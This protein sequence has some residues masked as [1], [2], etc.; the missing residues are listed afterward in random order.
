MNEKILLIEDNVELQTLNKLLFTEEGY[1]VDTAMTLSEAS[2]IIKT[3]MPHII[4]LDIGL[5][6]G[7]GLE[8]LSEF[9]KTSSVPVLMLTGFTGKEYELSGFAKGCDDF[10]AK[11]YDFDLL[12]VRVQR[13]LKSAN[14]IPEILTFGR[15]TLNNL[16][17]TAFV[18]DEDMGLSPKEFTLLQIFAQNKN[19]ALI[20]AELYEKLGVIPTENT[21]TL[22][23]Y[24]SRI[25]KRLLNSGYTIT[26]IYGGGFIFEED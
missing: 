26:K 1:C 22:T 19:K 24:I 12:L 13:L 7:S 16:S 4:I 15:L 18:D 14:Q 9:R 2:Q 5:P 8:F 23:N 11:P 3:N 25:R 20:P 17:L 21:R 6:D 10:L